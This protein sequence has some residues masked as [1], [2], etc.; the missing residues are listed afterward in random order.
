MVAVVS[1]QAAL[2]EEESSE[3]DEEEVQCSSIKS[4]DV[5]VTLAT[6]LYLFLAEK[7]EEQATDNQQVLSAIQDVKLSDKTKSSLHE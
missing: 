1:G 5:A 7:G 2:E 3:R 6:D 4:F